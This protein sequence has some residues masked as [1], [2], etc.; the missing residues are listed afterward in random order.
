MT[1]HNLFKPKNLEEGK[2]AVVGNCNGFT[3]QQRWEAETPAFAKKILEHLKL[4][5]KEGYIIDYGCGVGRLAKE[6]LLRDP[7]VNLLGVDDSQD[8]LNQAEAYV[9]NPKFYPQLPNSIA[10]EIEVDLAYC[11]YVLQHVPAIAIR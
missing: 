3:M 8:M 4:K 7:T 10:S 11:V 9:D 1:E 5:R 2:N 6:I